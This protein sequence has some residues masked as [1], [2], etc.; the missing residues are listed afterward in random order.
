MLAHIDLSDFI[1]YGRIVGCMA[2]FLFGEY[3]LIEWTIKAEG[4]GA[5]TWFRYKNQLRP[6][7]KAYAPNFGSKV[8]V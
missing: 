3:A 8:K 4:L 7:A 2:H 1:W 6:L 5:V